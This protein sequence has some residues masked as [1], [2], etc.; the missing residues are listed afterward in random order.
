MVEQKYRALK[1]LVQHL[2]GSELNR[3]TELI[4]STIIDQRLQVTAAFA[5]QRDAEVAAFK[6]HLPNQRLLFHGSR[7]SNFLGLLS[8]GILLPKLVVRRGGG[9]TDAGLLGNGLYFAEA[10][11]VSAQYAHPS[12][13]GSRS[14]TFFCRSI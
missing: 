8:R 11:D 2:E 14:V 1:C 12:A 10:A 5:I 6:S 7:F 4:Q 3:I 9:R 13:S